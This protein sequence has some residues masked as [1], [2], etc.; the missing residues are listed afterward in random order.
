MILYSRKQKLSDFYTLS[1]T[2][3]PKNRTLHHDT[4]PY[5]LY[6]GVPTSHPEACKAP[7]FCYFDQKPG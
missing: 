1:Q 3:V 2:K 5:S 4:Y 7:N 6:M